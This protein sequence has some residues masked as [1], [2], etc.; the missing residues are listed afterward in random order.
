VAVG[1]LGAFVTGHS[2][3]ITNG[4]QLH[5]HTVEALAFEVPAATMPI[6]TAKMAKAAAVAAPAGV[7]VASAPAERLRA[8]GLSVERWRAKGAAGAGLPAPGRPP[9]KKAARLPIPARTGNRGR[10]SCPDHQV[11]ALQA[12]VRPWRSCPLAAQRWPTGM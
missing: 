4:Q 2:A 11:P 6:P 7:L 10:L 9:M 1:V 3:T 12:M 5:A 8:E